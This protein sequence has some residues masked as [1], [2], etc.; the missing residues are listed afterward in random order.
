MGDKVV[1]LK[2]NADNPM[3]YGLVS[4]TDAGVGGGIGAAEGPQHVTIYVQVNDLKAYLSNVER[5]RGKTVVPPTE[6]PGMVTFALFTDP[7]GNTVGLV[8]G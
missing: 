3:S 6:I 4:G 2:V 8:K 5:L 7:D 1:H